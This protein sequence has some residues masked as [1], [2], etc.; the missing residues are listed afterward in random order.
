MRTWN[1]INALI[2]SFP[3]IFKAVK[4]CSLVF[5]VYHYQCVSPVLSPWLGLAGAVAPNSIRNS[6]NIEQHEVNK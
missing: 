2:V 4:G 3:S 1:K 5:C 6:S